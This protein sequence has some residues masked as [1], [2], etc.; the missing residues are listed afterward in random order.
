VDGPAAARD[1]DDRLLFG[2][3]GLCASEELD[4][5]A[6]SRLVQANFTLASGATAARIRY[7]RDAL[8]LHIGMAT[9][10]AMGA[11]MESA[12]FCA[13]AQANRPGFAASLLRVREIEGPDLSGPAPAL[14]PPP[15]PLA[16]R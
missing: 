16:A 1:R 4:P 13:E 2:G 6:V 15:A 7:R 11:H 10:L 12:A 3:G 14:A 5:E 8:S 9:G